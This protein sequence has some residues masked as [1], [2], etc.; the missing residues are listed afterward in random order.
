MT[1][2]EIV[3]LC[4][5][6]A[7]LGVSE[8][9]FADDSDGSEDEKAQKLLCAVNSVLEQLYCDF[10]CSLKRAKVSSQN[11]FIETATL[12]LNRVIALT[13]GYGNNIPYRYTENGLAV[14]DGNYALVYALLPNEVGWNDEVVLPTPRVT[15]RL[16]S[17]GVVAEYLFMN[18]DVS[19][20]ENWETRYKNALQNANVKSSSCNLPVGRWV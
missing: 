15:E 3:K 13:D 20:S 9:C 1:V 5:K 12:R 8:S 6:M 18:G 16:F 14:P 4:D 7:D 10:A 11:G 17:Y 19:A 2:K